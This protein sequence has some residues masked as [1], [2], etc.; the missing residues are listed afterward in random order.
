MGLGETPSDLVKDLVEHGAA[1]VHVSQRCGTWVIPREVAK[2]PS[3]HCETRLVHDRP[4]FHRIAML[5]C[6]A[7]LAAFWSL[8]PTQGLVA[9]ADAPHSGSAPSRQVD[10]LAHR[11][12]ELDQVRQHL[13]GARYG[14]GKPAWGCQPARRKQGHLHGRHKSA[15]YQP[16]TLLL[17]PLKRAEAAPLPRNA[18]D[19]CKLTIPPHHPTIAFIGYAQ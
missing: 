15:G 2:P 1:Q 13:P 3:D 12:A 14:A 4:M 9:G 11:V 10:P 17:P 19:L 18:R 5:I 7:A 16:G 8:Q 6:G